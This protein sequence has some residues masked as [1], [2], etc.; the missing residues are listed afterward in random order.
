MPPAPTSPATPYA[1]VRRLL[2]DA[3]RCPDCTAPLTRSRCDACGLELSGA[4]GQQLWDLSRIAADA[5]SRRDSYLQ[6]MRAQQL[7]RE[8]AQ[9]RSAPHPAA[10]AAQGVL[11]SRTSAPGQST[12][13]PVRSVVSGSLVAAAR[14]PAHAPD[15]VVPRASRSHW[16]V[17]TVLQVLGASLLAAAS[18]VFLV[19]SW[20][21]IGLTG[22]AVTVAVGTVVVFALADRLRRAAL[23]SSAEAVGALGTVMLLLD[24]WAVTATG[25]ITVTS[26]AAYDS[27]A[28]LV[29]AVLLLAGSRATQLR[30]ARVVGTA[31]L[32]LAPV[33]LVPL[34]TSPVA[35]AWL[36][37]GS[38]VLACGR[39]VIDRPTTAV[40]SPAAGAWFEPAVLTGAAWLMTVA[41]ALVA[42]GGVLADPRGD[43][44][45][46]VGALAA[47]AGLGALQVW[48][49]RIMRRTVSEQVGPTDRSWWATADS[50]T[51]WAA[52]A[53]AVAAT[54]SAAAAVVTGAQ[55][56]LP[57]ASLLALVPCGSAAVVAIVAAAAARTRGS[58]PVRT[59]DGAAPPP[60][61][62]RIRV[63]D[64][65]A[66]GAL[67]VALLLGTPAV[68]V[69]PFAAA[70]AT[71]EPGGVNRADV[72]V[73]GLAGAAVVAALLALAVRSPGPARTA[74]RCAAWLGAGVVLGVPAVAGTAIP[75]LVGAGAVALFLVTGAVAYGVDRRLP[76]SHLARTA[77]RAPLRALSALAVPASLVATHG[78][79]GL[80]AASLAGLAALA[81]GVRPW[82]VGAERG[83]GQARAAAAAAAAVAAWGAV[84]V[85]FGAAGVRSPLGALL[86]GG[87]G[88]VL[89]TPAALSPDARWPRLDRCT[90]LAAIGA[91]A[92][93]GWAAGL[94]A[95]GRAG[96]PA[97]QEVFVV[98]VAALA[99]VTVTSVLVGGAD[100]LG[101]RTRRVA[102]ALFAPVVVGAVVSLHLALGAHDGPGLAAGIAGAGAPS[103]LL[104][105]PL[106]STGAPA[107][108]ARDEVLR[109]VLEVT[110]WLTA[111]VALVVA[112][113][114][115]GLAL[116][117]LVG[118]ITAG[119]WSLQA[120]RR[121][122]RWGVLVL[123]TAAS[124]AL[125]HAG[126]VGVPEAYV[127]PAGLVLTVVGARRRRRGAPADAPLLAA[128]LALALVPTAL[129][130]GVL[131]GRVPRAGLTLAA[132]ALVVAI[133]LR[134][135]SATPPD[136]GAAPRRGQVDAVHVLLLIGLLVVVVGPARHALSAAIATVGGSASRRGAFGVLRIEAWSGAA[137]LLVATATMR[138][139]SLWRWATY[140]PRT[141][142]WWLVAAVAA[143]PSLVA[144]DRTAAGFVRWTIPLALGGT[145]A[146]H[147]ARALE[148]GNR[149]PGQR[150]AGRADWSRVVSLGLT[151][152]SASAL[153]AAIRSPL[154]PDVPVAILGVV[155]TAAG[156]TRWR[157]L[158]VSAPGPAH[159]GRTAPWLTA[160][161]PL[162]GPLLL[163]PA[164]FD[165]HGTWRTP[166]VLAGALALVAI[167]LRLTPRKSNTGDDSHDVP[168]PA[169]MDRAR[170]LLLV[171][172]ASLAVAGPGVRATISAAGSPDPARVLAVEAWSLPAAAVI[173]IAV[174]ALVRMRRAV[175][176]LPVSDPRRW[177]LALVLTTAAAPT[178]LAVDGSTTGLIRVV[179]VL[180]AGSGLAIVGTR[181]AGGARRYLGLCLTGAAAVAWTLR[182][183]PE[184]ADVPIVIAGCVLLVVGSLD[185]AAVRQRSSWHG[186]GAGLVL[187]LV[188][189]LASGWADPTAWR[190]W[191][192][193][194][195]AVVAVLVGAVRR[196]QAPFALGGVVLILLALVQLSPAAAAAL[197]VVEWWMLL[198]VGGAILLGLGLTYERRL[199]EATEAVR[200]VAAMR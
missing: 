44:P 96:Q 200:F 82:L 60:R 128:G 70:R 174:L 176:P 199:R 87:I 182:D 107:R 18:I 29:C 141:W 110:G 53:G 143:T 187:T 137:A 111:C 91:L 12:R 125:L 31:L 127:A 189:P 69:L 163:L 78:S 54:A 155:V 57:D 2:A 168:A 197:R 49:A 102:G 154:P 26:H 123:G 41:G 121:A 58:M 35:A 134:L 6:A 33:L 24:A 65:A 88:L 13:E 76:D 106:A 144:V 38:V 71:I 92:G 159:P 172:G 156:V 28:S 198:A 40:A 39:F 186:L 153:V 74:R 124:W 14:H 93:G 85:G 61:E 136:D 112:G 181:A 138:L 151:L 8:A 118:A 94:A 194:A 81:L 129:L 179:A 146:V 193:L 45:A 175:L 50:A 4:P 115:G 158:A 184:P 15:P 89:V 47:L 105:L 109:L 183:G 23:R 66:D 22:R 114:P 43:G 95:S 165:Q 36:L 75:S 79:P 162:A 196:W 160:P 67:L 7:A 73:A 166:A 157:R 101:D 173:G 122:A 135:R 164:A 139:T 42:V 17:Q 98:L 185:M 103:V 64:A 120:D 192:V 62:A 117:L 86:A 55:L 99:A 84:L 126:D 119:A 46:G 1:V 104:G 147:G 3:T 30:V 21:W 180:L 52:A 68:L 170:Q 116:V 90:T 77:L 145:L 20:G 5:L 56:D 191:L 10:M 142:G 178:L 152:A 19:F 32:P 133:G 27:A 130:D 177:G 51:W 149:T 100:A 59:A 34:A 195:G 63:S 140:S 188:V 83:L 97:A 150:P 113:G 16:R 9:H 169:V 48:L 11:L 161:W 80:V 37:A 190:L 167:G 72:A 132:G 25:L 108:R 148:R 171:S 131:T